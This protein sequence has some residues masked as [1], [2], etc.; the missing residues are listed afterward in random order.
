MTVEVA[1]MKGEVQA[2]VD[3]WERAGV[4]RVRTW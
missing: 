2:H 4:P 1:A 3:V